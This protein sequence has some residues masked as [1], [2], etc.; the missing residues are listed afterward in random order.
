M[1]ANG[2]SAEVPVRIK[3]A[4]ISVTASSVAHQ[5]QLFVWCAGKRAEDSV[6]VSSD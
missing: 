6:K 2:Q 1:D 4:G 3:S 5:D